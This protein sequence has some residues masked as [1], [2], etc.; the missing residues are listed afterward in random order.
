MSTTIRY[1]ELGDEHAGRDIEVPLPWLDD[2]APFVF[3]SRGRPGQ[4][5]VTAWSETRDPLELRD[6]FVHLL[7]WPD[8]AEGDVQVYVDAQL[9]VQD[10][11]QEA[12]T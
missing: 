6:T 5:I 9:T 12:T 1:D 11:T 7:R 4:Q 10:R 2:P 8:G 3:V